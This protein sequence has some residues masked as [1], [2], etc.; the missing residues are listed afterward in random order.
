MGQGLAILLIGY[1]AGLLFWPFALQN[2][3]QNPLESLQVMEHYKVSIRQIFNGQWLW[4]TQLPWYYLPKWLLI[5]TPE[6]YIYGF[7]VFLILFFRNFIKQ[8][9]KQLFYELFLLFT[10]FF[11]LVYVVIIKANLYSGVRQMLFVLPI[12]VVFTSVGNIWIVITLFKVNYQKL[13]VGFIYLLLM[14]L[15]I[16][17]QAATFPADYIYFNSISGGNKKAWSNMN[18]IIIFMD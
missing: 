4:S 16:K 18:M 6:L 2:V 14:I 17:H 11:P 10:L 9:N 13:G 7:S 15:P 5:S 3:F 12:L 1:F 8:D